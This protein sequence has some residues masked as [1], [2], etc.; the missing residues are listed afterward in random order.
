MGV[1][2]REIALHLVEQLRFPF[3]V[4]HPTKGDWN[5]Q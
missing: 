5:S 2:L 1:M 4:L 3:V